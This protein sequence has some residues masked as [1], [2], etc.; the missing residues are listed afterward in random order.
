M[1]DPNTPYLG[2]PVAWRRHW[3]EALKGCDCFGGFDGGVV[4]DFSSQALYF[5]VQRKVT[6]P[7]LL[8]WAW[9]PAEVEHHRILKEKFGYQEWVEGGFL[10]LMPGPVTRYDI[11]EADILQLSRDYNI[12][13]NAFDKAYITQLVQRLIAAGVNMVTQVRQTA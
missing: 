1:P 13:E 3:I 6:K 11:L 5:P 7:I 12:I 4:N 9:A 2:N 10:T 8:V